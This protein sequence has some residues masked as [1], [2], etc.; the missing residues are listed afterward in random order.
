MGLE[1]WGEKSKEGAGQ[2]GI[3]R[4]V[5][6]GVLGAVWECSDGTD[7]A[8]RV[9]QEAAGAE[10]GVVGLVSTSTA[11]SWL[12]CSLCSTGN[13]LLRPFGMCD[14]TQAVLYFPPFL[15]PLTRQ[16]LQKPCDIVGTILPDLTGYPTE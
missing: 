11:C 10:R 3:Y 12:L 7:P 13:D 5:A 15:S 1:W 8:R 4:D 16:C 6:S 14:A 2:A 9:G